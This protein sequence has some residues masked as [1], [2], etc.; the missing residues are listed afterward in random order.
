LAWC[1]IV[2]I[3]E[4]VVMCEAWI[5]G[6]RCAGWRR[7]S[8]LRTLALDDLV[9]ARPWCDCLTGLS[10]VERLPERFGHRDGYYGR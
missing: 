10:T 8:S 1:G 9:R 6:W 7:G 2:A 4:A 3:D 5:K